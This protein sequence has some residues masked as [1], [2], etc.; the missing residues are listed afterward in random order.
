MKKMVDAIA[1][2]EPGTKPRAIGVRKRRTYAKQF[3]AEVVAQCLLPGASVSAIA[4]SHDINANVVR[5]WLPPGTERKPQSP[6]LLPVTIEAD[7]L[8]RSPAGPPLTIELNL[9]GATLHL[10]PGF[11]EQD[12]R[13]VLNVLRT[14]S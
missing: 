1:M 9:D 7:A 14:L 10:P 2:Q 3:K 5:R 13:N 12:L 6:M 8:M 11:A 4:L